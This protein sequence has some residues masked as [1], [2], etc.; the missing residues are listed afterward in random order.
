MR[1]T[2]PNAALSR[3][4]RQRRMSLLTASLNE[5]AAMLLSGADGSF[6]FCFELV[7]QLAASVVEPF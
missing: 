3:I 4:N 7:E 2:M 6:V 5:V 1:T